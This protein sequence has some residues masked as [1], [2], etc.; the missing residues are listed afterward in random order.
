MV[1]EVP[2]ELDLVSVL[3]NLIDLDPIRAVL[4]D[5]QSRAEGGNRIGFRCG[6][7]A[8]EFGDIRH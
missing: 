2:T 7:G 1:I 6:L 5:L 4:K 3:V 8:A